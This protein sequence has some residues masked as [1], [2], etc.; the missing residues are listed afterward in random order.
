MGLFYIRIKAT[1]R[2]WVWTKGA[3][4]CRG[5]D[6]SCSI[7]KGL[8]LHT[9]NPKENAQIKTQHN[10]DHAS[11]KDLEWGDKFT[12]GKFYFKSLKCDI[13]EGR[14]FSFILIFT[15]PPET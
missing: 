9:K 14:L 5:L 2:T 12:S 6:S 4:N 15:V 8:K 11:C 13:D 7:N 3:Q 10:Y 1:S